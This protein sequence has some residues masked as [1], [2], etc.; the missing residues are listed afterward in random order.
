M[1]DDDKLRAVA[2]EAAR[3]A[4]A[5]QLQALGLDPSDPATANDIYELK[6]L[7]G[8]WRATKTVG[9]TIARVVTVAVLSALAA[10][11]FMYFAAGTNSA[12]RQQPSVHRQHLDGSPILRR[13]AQPATAAVCRRAR[14]C[15]PRRRGDR[16][17]PG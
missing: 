11:S 12:A 4:V 7:L 2:R 13:H 10:G 9:Q 3:E 16:R 15:W 8:A 17:L 5:L 14:H 6:G 1:T